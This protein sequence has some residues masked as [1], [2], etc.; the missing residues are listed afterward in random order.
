VIATTTTSTTGSCGGCRPTV[1]ATAASAD[2]DNLYELGAR[3]LVPGLVVARVEDL[4]IYSAAA[5]RMCVVHKRYIHTINIRCSQ[6]LATH[7]NLA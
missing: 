7:M 6:K 4:Y 2:S 3:R 5:T 1:T